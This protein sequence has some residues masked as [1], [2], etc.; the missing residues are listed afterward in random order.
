VRQALPGEKL[1]T[2][3]ERPLSLEVAPAFGGAVLSFELERPSGRV[4]LFRPA[5][6]EARAGRDRFG[7]A[8]LPLVPFSNRIRLGHFD[9]EGR[10]YALEPNVAGHP[11]PLHGHGWLGPWQVLEQSERAVELSFAYEGDDW[12]SAYRA[13]R[14]LELG[15]GPHGLGELTITMTLENTGTRRMPA[16][17]GTHPYFPRTPRTRFVAKTEHVW[18]ADETCIPTRRIPV[19]K[20]WDARAGLSPDTVDL[21]H[22]FSGWDG[23][24]L[25][26]QPDHSLSLRLEADRIFSHFV[27]YTPPGEDFF[28]AEPVTHA[29]DAVNLVTRGES[30][31]GFVVLEPGE[32]LSGRVRFVVAPG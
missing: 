24:A 19:P 15:R 30:D 22:C 28:C 20:E 25:I 17:L 14:R 4:P 16:G 32:E 7:Y 23:A 13:R 26:E 6:A 18:L 3:A 31:V 9:F 29:N 11:H 10:S 12:P 5:S 21:N 8:C 1:I 2:V 27:V